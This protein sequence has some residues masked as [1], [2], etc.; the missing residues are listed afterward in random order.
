MVDWLSRLVNHLTVTRG[1][2]IAVLMRC[3]FILARKVR[4][5]IAAIRRKERDGVYRRCLFAP[6]ARTGVSFDC[7]FAF[8]DGMYRGRPCY[9]GRWR[10]RKHFLGPDRVP[11]FDGAQDGEEF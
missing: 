5:K 11:A 10:P 8:R 9:R 2:R 3:K 1:M 6:E 4:G 7:A